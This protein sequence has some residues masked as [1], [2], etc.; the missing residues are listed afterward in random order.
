QLLSLFYFTVHLASRADE[1]REKA[2]KTL[3]DVAHTEDEKNKY[4]AELDRKG[5]VFNKLKEFRSLN[6]RNL[7]TTSVDAVMWYLSN[8]IQNAMA[9]RPEMLRSSETITIDEVMDIK[10]RKSLLTYL[11]DRKVNSLSYGGIRQLEK[12]IRDRLGADLFHT[13]DERDLLNIFIELRN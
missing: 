3:M 7:T 5:I 10:T 6:S 2:T 9:R 4:K 12:Y 11:I 8:I 13:D 1:V